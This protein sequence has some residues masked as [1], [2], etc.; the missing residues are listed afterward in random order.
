METYIIFSIGLL[1]KFSITVYDN[2]LAHNKNAKLLSP[3]NKKLFILQI[4]IK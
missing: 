3:K 2:S 4:W 1:K